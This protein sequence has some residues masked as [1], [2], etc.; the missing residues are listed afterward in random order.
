MLLG[1]ESLIVG[2]NDDLKPAGRFSF[3]TAKRKEIREEMMIKKSAEGKGGAY[4]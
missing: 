3:R 1:K 4:D 2:T